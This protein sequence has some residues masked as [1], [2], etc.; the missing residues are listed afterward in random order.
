M[1]VLVGSRDAQRGRKVGFVLEGSRDAQSGRCRCCVL[2]K[3]NR[4]ERQFQPL[5]KKCTT[6]VGGNERKRFEPQYK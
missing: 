6:I 3:V 4:R 2:R 5:M 1:Y